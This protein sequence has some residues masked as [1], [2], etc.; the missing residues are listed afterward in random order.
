MHAKGLKDTDLESVLGVGRSMVTK[1]RLRTAKPSFDVAKK[2]I[3]Y[4][5][6]RVRLCDL[7]PHED[8]K[9]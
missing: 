8:S 9:A 3:E 4:S 7:V 1:L 6:G 2:I 5:R